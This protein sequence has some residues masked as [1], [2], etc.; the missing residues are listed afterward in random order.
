MALT[1][2][3]DL[4]WIPC[5]V[6]PGPFS[7]ERL[8]RVANG[9]GEAW[10]GFVSVRFLREAIREGA[11]AIKGRVIELKGDSLIASLP[12]EALATTLY[13]GRMSG[14]ELVGSLKA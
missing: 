10:T 8:V 9:G 7:N 5:E 13:T 2:T 4:I 3:G 11:T 14:V 12:G 6:K 1:K